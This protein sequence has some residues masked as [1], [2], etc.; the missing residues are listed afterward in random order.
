[1]ALLRRL[2]KRILVELPTMEARVD[3]MV[4]NIPPKMCEPKI[5]YQAFAEQLEVSD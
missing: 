2:E 1:M 4:N 3:M 5:N